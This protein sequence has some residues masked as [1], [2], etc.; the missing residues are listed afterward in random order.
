MIGELSNFPLESTT[1]LR[2]MS[3]PRHS[4]TTPKQTRKQARQ[5]I[6]LRLRQ[7]RAA[8]P[9]HKRR[10]AACALARRL[11]GYLP[12]RRA[13]HIGSYLAHA[14]ELDTLPALRRHH[15]RGQTLYLPAISH[16]PSMKMT[17]RR[18]SESEQML[19]NQYGIGEPQRSKQR[20]RPL[21]ALD[22]LLIPLVAFDRDGN[23]LGMGGGY[24]D[25][26]LASLAHRPSRPRLIGIGYR[27]QEVDRV[28]AEP[29]DMPLDLT[30]TD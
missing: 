20:S 7:Q 2:P 28:P 5:Q 30:L 12:F 19:T 25:R 4:T 21:W 10:S 29:W 1:R 22:V 14:G 8:L 23:R 15:C 16:A 18:W 3:Q 9:T 24:Y 17:M 26:L 11:N 27:F 6:R 13:R